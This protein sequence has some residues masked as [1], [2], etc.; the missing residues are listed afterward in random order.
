MQ[1]SS[2]TFLQ[3]DKKIMPED[4][5]IL[6]SIITKN[7]QALLANAQGNSNDMWLVLNRLSHGKGFKLHEGD[8]IRFGKVVYRVTKLVIDGISSRKPAT[9]TR[10]NTPVEVPVAANERKQPGKKMRSADSCRIC[11]SGHFTQRNPLITPCK[12][13]GTMRHIHVKCLQQWLKTKIVA[14]GRGSSKTYALKQLGCELCKEPLPMEVNI[15]GKV[16]D[17]M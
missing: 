3:N 7:G 5:T 1:N 2:E 13:Q 17:L 9:L 14:R 12:C 11:L 10:P 4:T 6:A 16:V 8:T 15:N